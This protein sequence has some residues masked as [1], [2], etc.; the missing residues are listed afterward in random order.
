MIT[1]FYLTHR[2]QPNTLCL[3]GHGSN[4]N[5]EVLHIMQSSRTKASNGLVIFRSLI[6]GGSVACLHRHSWHILQPQP[7]GL[8][9]HIALIK[10]MLYTAQ[11]AGAVEYT[12]RKKVRLLQVSWI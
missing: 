10:I 2:C 8:F 4:G 6:G 3:S 11:L 7:T 9:K 1:Y 5:E 12:D